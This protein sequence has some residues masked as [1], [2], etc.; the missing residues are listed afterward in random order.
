MLLRRVGALG[1]NLRSHPF[2]S[3]I[4]YYGVPK[5]FPMYYSE[6][7][8]AVND[9]DQTKFFQSFTQGKLVQ[10]QKECLYEIMI[11]PSGT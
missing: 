10:A 1:R 11:E 7:T 3:N 6:A 5:I 4:N 8:V 9:L 2:G